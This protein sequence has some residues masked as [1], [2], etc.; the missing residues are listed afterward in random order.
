PGEEPTAEST[1]F[2]SIVPMATWQSGLPQ[3]FPRPPRPAR[4]KQLEFLAASPIVGYEEFLQLPQQVAVHIAHL[5]NIAIIMGLSCHGDQPIVSYDLAAFCL[6]GL[7]GADELH[8]YQT[9][10]IRGHVHEN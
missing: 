6:L 8:L 10:W 3:E 7:D 4:A 2:H 9:A 1:E 5:P